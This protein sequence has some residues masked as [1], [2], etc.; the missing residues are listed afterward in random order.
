MSNYDIP[1]L[2]AYGGNPN[3][4][5]S[6]LDQIKYDLAGQINNSFSNI[7]NENKQRNVN[8]L[9]LSKE[10][11]N[12]SQI[13]KEEAVVRNDLKQQRQLTKV[14]RMKRME[15]MQHN[16]LGNIFNSPIQHHRM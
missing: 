2:Q 1:S 14:K 11:L 4:I 7:A 3:T 9:K 15:T 16:A 6:S 8:N 10:S 13:Y 12:A 5:L